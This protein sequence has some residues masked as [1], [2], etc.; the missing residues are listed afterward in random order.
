MQVRTRD[1]AAD[2]DLSTTDDGEVVLYLRDGM[3]P[4]SKVYALGVLL[5]EVRA[6]LSPVER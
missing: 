4:R 1:M 2:F 3:L 6:V 5:E